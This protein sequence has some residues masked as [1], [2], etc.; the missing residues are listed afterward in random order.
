M[1]P[2]LAASTRPIGDQAGARLHTPAKFRASRSMPAHVA[3]ERQNEEQ[4]QARRQ[5]ERRGR[6][7]QNQKRTTM[8]VECLE[9]LVRTDRRR[10]AA[11]PA[12]AAR[13]EAGTPDRHRSC[14]SP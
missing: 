6:Q 8:R 9:C 5:P 14:D 1:L 12:S 7:V 11:D 4:E 13:A 2:A 10:R 3:A